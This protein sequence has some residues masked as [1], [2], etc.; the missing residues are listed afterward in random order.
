MR[1]ESGRCCTT[2]SM[3][4]SEALTTGFPCLQDTNNCPTI[5]GRITAKRYFKVLLLIFIKRTNRLFIVCPNIIIKRRRSTHYA[6]PLA[7]GGRRKRNEVP[8]LLHIP[9]STIGILQLQVI[10]ADFI[11]FQTNGTSYLVSVFVHALQADIILISI[12]H[13]PIPRE[14]Q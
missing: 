12:Y 6:A 10:S 4:S 8:F 11:P 5:S 14:F 3:W 1:A 2:C 7:K 13:L 9:P